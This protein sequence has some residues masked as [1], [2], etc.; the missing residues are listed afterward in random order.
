MN[1]YE[2]FRASNGSSNDMD[3]DDIISP[4]LRE[5][6]HECFS[7]RCYEFMCVNMCDAASCS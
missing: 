2:S 1:R 5:Q 6:V 4:E 7:M 3:L